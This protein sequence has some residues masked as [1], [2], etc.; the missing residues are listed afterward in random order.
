MGSLLPCGTP[1]AYKRHK[2]RGETACGPCLEAAREY[3]RQQRDRN[4]G[5]PPREPL[6]C[7]T[8]AGFARHK[9]W[10]ETPCGP[11]REAEREYR[12][13]RREADG[14]IV[15]VRKFADGMWYYGSAVGSI[16]RR[17][18]KDSSLPVSGK[19]GNYID[20]EID[21]TTEVLARC[22]SKEVAL[23]MEARLILASDR[24]KLLNDYVPWHFCWE[25]NPGRRA[26]SFHKERGETPCGPAMEAYRKYQ[27]EYQSRLRRKRKAD[28][29]G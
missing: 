25:P 19:L 8:Q 16:K 12:K 5:R 28:G 13:N 23:Q 17:L 6:P 15:Y 10:G 20:N 29:A 24:S 7:G 3:V 22:D 1:A 26:Y 2:K 4:R 21:F 14:W 18:A 11:C 9:Y 27:R